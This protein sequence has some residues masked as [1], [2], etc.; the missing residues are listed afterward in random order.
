MRFGIFVLLLFA[1]AVTAQKDVFQCSI[2]SECPQR[3]C[4]VATCSKDDIC[5]YEAS[6]CELQDGDP[7]IVSLGCDVTNDQCKYEKLSCNDQNYCTKDICARHENGEAYCAYE[8]LSDCESAHQVTFENKEAR[9]LTVE[10][11]DS[12]TINI[13][14]TTEYIH[15]NEVVVLGFDAYRRGELFARGT[16][17]NLIDTTTDDSLNDRLSYVSLSVPEKNEKECSL[18]L[19]SSI[20]LDGIFSD[21]TWQESSTRFAF[22][23]NGLL[24]I[25]GQ[26]D[27]VGDNQGLSFVVDLTFQYI[28]D[29]I[30]TPHLPDQCYATL[31]VNIDSWSLYRLS[32]GRLTAISKSLYDGLVINLIEGRLQ[33]G[34]GASGVNMNR[35]FWSAFT[36]S[37]FN[38][39]HNQHLS[40][41][42]DI[43][44]GDMRGDLQAHFEPSD[45]TSYCNLFNQNRQELISPLWKPSHGEHSL[46]Y[47]SLFTTNDLLQCRDNDDKYAPM[48]TRSSNTDHSIISGTLHHSVVSRPSDCN[49]PTTEL[50]RMHTEYDLKLTLDSLNSSITSIATTHSDVDFEV[51][52]L[53]NVWLCCSEENSGNLQVLIE[54]RTQGFSLTNARVQRTDETGVMLFFVDADTN[55]LDTSEVC[56][57]RWALRTYNAKSLVDFSGE[58]TLYWTVSKV[59]FTVSTRMTI[60]AKHVGEQTHLTDGRLS[61]TSGLYTNRA[62]TTE[63]NIKSGAILDDTQLFGLVCLNEYR[64]LDLYLQEVSICY[65]DESTR[66]IVSCED[67]NAKKVLIYSRKEEII[68]DHKFELL[69]DPPSTTHCEGFSFL[70]KTHVQTQQKLFISWST[71]EAGG[72]GGLIE[73]FSDDDDDHNHTNHWHD[74]Q[75]PGYY[76]HCPSGWFYDPY[77]RECKIYRDRDES[78]WLWL[79][80]FLAILF[81]LIWIPCRTCNE[82]KDREDASRIQKQFEPPR[83]EESFTETPKESAIRFRISK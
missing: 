33:E 74:D 13:C 19:L 23:E 30:V 70:A 59:Q 6:Q 80:V 52:W 34:Y 35:G 39:P 10:Q 43:R 60:I 64:H 3:N 15:E 51:K 50:P 48:F 69:R 54:T 27:S 20:S 58:K 14:H 65:A 42:E 45:T 16:C 55:C 41:I 75:G 32:R 66:D 67:K 11:I 38:Q 73:M 21:F 62:F 61:I 2:D 28:N 68:T 81:L 18:G 72:E 71:Q 36:W 7:C 47:C 53:G 26:I 63:Y 24:H 4:L 56:V 40:L 57:Q 25:N 49:V 76:S 29:N 46:T 12:N 5:V 44:G 17:D 83:E 37:V 79:I 78:A 31:N 8:P 22:G 82:T 77:G 9:R 1:A